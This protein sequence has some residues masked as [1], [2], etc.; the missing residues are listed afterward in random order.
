MIDF[1]GAD[2]D[3]LCADGKLMLRVASPDQVILYGAMQG[4]GKHRP[5]LVTANAEL[6]D[7]RFDAYMPPEEFNVMIQTCFLESETRDSVLA[8]TGS[9]RTEQ[10]LQ[11]ADDGFSQRVTINR[12]AASAATAIVRNPFMLAPRRTFAEVTQPE[13]PFVLRFDDGGKVA[14]FAADG[15]AWKIDAVSNIRMFLDT[16]L[17][18]DGKHVNIFVIA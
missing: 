1:T 10:S 8:L 14:L 2:T 6:P 4:Y 12:G 15:G 17:H 13:S 16:E 18:A 11:T 9:V 3:G 5:V 7:I